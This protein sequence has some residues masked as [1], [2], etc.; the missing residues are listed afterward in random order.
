MTQKEQVQKFMDIFFAG[1]GNGKMQE[2]YICGYCWHF[3]NMMLDT[4]RRGYV[5]LAAPFSHFVWV[6]TDGTPWEAGG[7]Y[8]G[9]AFYF[10]PQ[11]ILPEE[12]LTTFRHVPGETSQGM[13]KEH[14][15]GLMKSYCRKEGIAYDAKAEDYL[16]PI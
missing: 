11:D 15:I 3:A 4:F 5:A 2:R 9:E 1:D 7:I 10:I 12:E 13:A 6:D 8:D 16:V 14:A